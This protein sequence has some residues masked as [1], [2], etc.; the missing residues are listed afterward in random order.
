KNKGMKLNTKILVFILTTALVI[1]VAAIGYVSLNF[2][3]KSLNNAQQVSDAYTKQYASLCK[4]RLDEY[5]LVC[6]TVVNSFEQYESIPA[7]YRRNTFMQIMKDVLILNEEVLSVWTIWELEAIDGMDSL[8]VN[9][10][11]STHKGNFSPTFYKENGEI[12]LETSIET[13][14][15]QG[16][17]YTIPKSTLQET[18][19]DPYF[20]SYTGNKEDEIHQTSLVIPIV[21]NEEFKGVVG[22]DIPL[23]K[24]QELTTSISPF[25]GSYAL[26]LANNGAIVSHP[27]TAYI[28]KNFADI[29]PRINRKQKLIEKIKEAETVSF[30][31]K[32]IH[33]GKKK[34]VSL[35]PVKIGNSSTPWS[36]AIISPVKSIM[37]RVNETF[38]YAIFVGILGLLG[39]CFVILVISR[40]IS[41]PLTKI[42]KTLN[43]VS[44]GDIRKDNLLRI[45]SN[46]EIGEMAD[47]VNTLI[48]G[49][50][51][52]AG[53][54]HQ[55]GQGNLKAD[56]TLLSDDDILGNSLL[57][58]RHSLV[59]AEQE[60]KKRKSEDE[61]QNW[62]TRGVALF[63]EILREHSDNMEMMSWKIVEQL[64]EYMKLNQCTI[65]ILNDEDERNQFYEM[66]AAMAY[67]RRKPMKKEVEV[68][69]ELIGRAARERITIYLNNIPDDYVV[70]T[71]GVGEETPHHLL[72]VPLNL[73]DQIFG[74]IELI[75]F[76]PF[77]P[78]QI[79]FVEKI[80]ESIASTI[81]SVKVNSKTA[82]LLAQSQ[83]QAD[84]LTQHEEEMRQNMEE[85][86]ATQEEA[87]KREAIMRGILDAINS[88]SMVAEFDMQGRYLNLNER[89]SKIIGVS[90]DKLVGK[91]QGSYMT[92]EDEE[93]QEGFAEF[94]D[95][96]KRGES[97]RKIQH[98]KT[99]MREMWL[100]EIYTP[101]FDEHG[102][103]LKVINIAF[104]ITEQKL[105]EN[106][107][108]KL[109]STLEI[110]N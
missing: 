1:F 48:M 110:S 82:G 92:S 71:S 36:L 70:V 96:L 44:R 39:L 16:D 22:I 10:P 32:D 81:A 77:E 95:E 102:E 74:V 9:K 87:A 12:M 35:S 67:G 84:E 69:E 7:E 62:S 31:M 14:L 103:P 108:E 34:Y 6:R 25:A 5:M 3:Q 85:M 4:T 53:F 65:F 46:D 11:G 98:I 66:T 41:R 109:Q 59:I 26:L 105:L 49:L 8:Y 28:D 61:K 93:E 30:K 99:P 90:A 18:I 83:E 100:E 13:V 55:I 2:K 89:L 75:S 80:G 40:S 97:Q 88:V 63:N 47:S 94:W 91:I 37:V 45:K 42:N 29:F 38:I 86:Q 15:F 24:L 79:E 43:N 58:M 20:Y 78:Y 23:S 73:N 56:F 57:E 19:M 27:D 17:Y 72:I 51:G 60:E 21:V 52:T 107:I 101:I 104:D 64:S 68:G 106:Q 33:D 54:A 76:D 50:N